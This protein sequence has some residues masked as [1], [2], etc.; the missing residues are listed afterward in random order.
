MCRNE[1]NIRSTVIPVNDRNRKNGQPTSYYRNLMKQEF[2]KE[3]FGQRWQVE[4]VFSRFKR[5]LGYA[6]RATTEQ[7]RAIECLMRVLTYN[8]MIL[9]FT[10]KYGFYRAQRLLNISRMPLRKANWTKIQYVGNSDELVL[11]EKIIA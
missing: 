9:L 3:I 4:S 7:S 10:C 6:L 2:P 11:T 1:L 5:K 8:F